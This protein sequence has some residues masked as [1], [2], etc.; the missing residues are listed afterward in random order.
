MV[1]EKTERLRIGLHVFGVS[2]TSHWASWIIVGFI[3]CFVSAVTT[4]VAAWIS[5]FEMF[6]RTPILIFSAFFFINSLCMVAFAFLITTIV[7]SKQSGNTLSYSFIFSSVIFVIIF[8][9]VV[10]LFMMFFQE[11]TAQWVKW[12]WEVMYFYPAFNF[13]KGY[14]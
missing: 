14:G 13:A 3:Y 7:S 11:E 12:L 1:K 8:H 6:E 4:P 10:L 5:R 2:S 9:N